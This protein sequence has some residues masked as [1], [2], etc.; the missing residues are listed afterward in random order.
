MTSVRSL[1]STG[2][3]V[4]GAVDWEILGWFATKD[5]AEAVSPSR[6]AAG[7]VEL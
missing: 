6:T 3:L 7:V 1:A 4:A 5:G 2:R